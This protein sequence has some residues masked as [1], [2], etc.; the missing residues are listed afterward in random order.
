MFFF[1]RHLGLESK[2]HETLHVNEESR[3]KTNTEKP[4]KTRTYFS[5]KQTGYVPLKVV[6]I[7]FSGCGSYHKDTEN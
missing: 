2:E 6:L 5:N 4:R 3:G 1:D 7:K